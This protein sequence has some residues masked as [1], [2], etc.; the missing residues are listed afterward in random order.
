MAAIKAESVEKTALFI[1]I[2][3]IAGLVLGGLVMLARRGL[4]RRA[5][6]DRD[7]RG[8]VEKRFRAL[9]LV[10]SAAVS[11]A[12]GGNDAQKTMGVITALLVGVGRL[13]ARPDGSL[14]VPI[15]V[16]LLAYTAIA[17]GTVS[18]GWRIVRTTM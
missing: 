3:P 5:E 6:H 10:S 4:L 12:H 15:W 8:R 18:G 16:V 14:P 2:S 11:L 1:V 9:Q 13:P 17:L 7:A